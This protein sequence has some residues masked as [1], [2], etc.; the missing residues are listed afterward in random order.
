MG[1]STPE[2]SVTFVGAATLD[3][4]ALVPR[5]PQPDERLVA[6][7]IA[8]AGGGPAATAAV[9]AARGRAL[10]WSIAAAAPARSATALFRDPS[11]R[12]R[13]RRESSTRSGYT[14]TMSAGR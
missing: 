1:Q 14:S 8:Y 5:F 2:I 3:G 10:S 13:P 4:I 12:R 11:S 9:A 6:E 7:E